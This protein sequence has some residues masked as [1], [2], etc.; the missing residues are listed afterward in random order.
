MAPYNIV[1]NINLGIMVNKNSPNKDIIGPFTEW[2]T[3]DSSKTGY[4]YRAAS[5]D[6]QISVYH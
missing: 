5:G 3:L 2:L 6:F 4:Q 1:Y